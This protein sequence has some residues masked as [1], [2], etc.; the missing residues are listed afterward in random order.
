MPNDIYISKKYR[1]A[2]Y[3]SDSGSLIDSYLLYKKQS[4]TTNPAI[5]NIQFN[6]QKIV[7]NSE[8]DS[9]NIE[10][11]PFEFNLLNIYGENAIS[12]SNPDDLFI[13]QGS[14]GTC[15]T[16][17]FATGLSIKLSNLLNFP[18]RI[19]YCS[20]LSNLYD[21]Y[22]AHGVPKFGKF[23]IKPDGSFYE[24][25]LGIPI[26]TL[27]K[28]KSFPLIT[29]PYE[30]LQ[31][32]IPIT[33]YPECRLG[34]AP[35]LNYDDNRSF[36]LGLLAKPKCPKLPQNCGF[37]ISLQNWKKTYNLKTIC[38]IKKQLLS[39]NSIT[40]GIGGSL[41]YWLN[42]IATNSDNEFKYPQDY[43]RFRSLSTIGA[44]A[45]T[46]V[47]WSTPKPGYTKF[48]IKNSWL[49]KPTFYFTIK[50]TD[51]DNSWTIIFSN[52]YLPARRQEDYDIVFVDYQNKDLAEIR[53][54]IVENL[55]KCCGVGTCCGDSINEDFCE[56]NIT[57]LE[58]AKKVPK[59]L[60]VT[61]APVYH[62]IDTFYPNRELNNILK[63]N[64]I[65]CSYL[66]EDK[67]NIITDVSS[68][69]ENALK[70]YCYS[71]EPKDDM[72]R[73]KEYIIDSIG[74]F[75]DG[76]QTLQCPC[77]TEPTTTPEVSP[78]PFPS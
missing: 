54:D 75:L 35:P 65:Q 38:D 10:Q 71:S 30:Y 20:F 55:K 31:T 5:R 48:I 17:S 25:T 46:I 42:N 43:S 74:P 45:V 39:G 26:I 68:Q 40:I 58:C 8:C 18:F 28:L 76:S 64:E 47:G 57:E 14:A 70:I 59:T 24:T 67:Y 1:N 19:D 36:N 44:H 49:S 2:P 51:Y 73:L 56:E 78:T 21:L 9:D 11:L 77:S 60:S 69:L 29:Y 15:A 52:T 3:I 33:I 53:S 61:P 62:E 23:K 22:Y 7:N 32:H 37:K 13:E 16:V 50:N 34:D 72:L 4:G 41:L 12:L 6:S 27:P 63:D 66:L